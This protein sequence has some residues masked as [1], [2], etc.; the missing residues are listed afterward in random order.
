MLPNLKIE[1][2]SAFEVLDSRGNPTISV[3]LQL[4]DGSSSLAIV[5]SGASTGSH[6][7]LELRDQDSSRFHGKGVLKA[8]NFVKNEI[9]ESIIGLDPL[10]QKSLDIELCKIDGT[11]DKSFLG[12]NS[13]LAVSLANLKASAISSN[14]PLYKYVFDLNLDSIFKNESPILPVPMLNILNGGAHADNNIDVQEF[15]IQP[16]G[17]S[18]LKSAMRSGVEIFHELKKIL[19]D[20]NLSVSVGDEGGFAPQLSSAEE[21]LDLILKAIKK[22]GYEAGKDVFLCLDVASSEFFQDNKY[23]LKGVN[24]ELNKDEM[25]HFLKTLCSKYPI[26]SIEDGL[27][28]DDWEGWKSLTKIL[29][30]EIQIVGDDLFATNPERIKKGIKENVANSVLIKMNQIGTISETIEAVNLAQKNGYKAIISHRSG[31]T[32]DT[33]IS[34]LAT[35]LCAGQIKS[36][37]PSRTER[38]AKYN[39]L[40]IIEDKFKPPFIGKYE[41]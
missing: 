35:G 39:R 23:F 31:E 24:K 13:I 25:I 9:K 16:L 19:K 3:E 5:P 36:G 26:N 4:S 18:T 6:E 15:M 8:I 37:A 22:A 11:K 38:V 1:D 12:A 2:I 40:L 27:D 28:E 7:A 21:A 33:S 10:D 30:E 34:D 20:L 17:F 32:E 29:G 14:K 41:E